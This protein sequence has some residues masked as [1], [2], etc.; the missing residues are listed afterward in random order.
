MVLLDAAGAA[1]NAENEVSEDCGEYQDYDSDYE[2]IEPPYIPRGH[3]ND[4]EMIWYGDDEWPFHSILFTQ[5]S[6][7]KFV[8]SKKSS[9]D[10]FA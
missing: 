1:N 2:D 5:K 7:K 3:P 8:Y 9:Y 10:F 4:D 6:R